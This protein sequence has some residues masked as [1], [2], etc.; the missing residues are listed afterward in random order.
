M[1]FAESVAVCLP[2]V[3]ICT[4]VTLRNML[5]LFISSDGEKVKV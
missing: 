2:Y 3:D 5:T 4:K 1:F